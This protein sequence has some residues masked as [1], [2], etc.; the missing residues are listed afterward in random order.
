MG[1]NCGPRL[2][3][4]FLYSYEAEFIQSLISTGSKQL[5]SPFNTTYRFIGNV[6]SI[7]NLEVEKYLGQM[8]PVERQIKDTK[9][10]NTSAS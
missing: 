4:I 2:A 10:F 5:A 1:T 3:D 9:E 6:L 8:Y 7:N